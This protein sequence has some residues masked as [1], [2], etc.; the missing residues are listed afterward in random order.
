MQT[1][2][3]KT[4]EQ[5]FKNPLPANLAWSSIENLFLALGAQKIEGRGSRVRFELSGVI[6][7]FHRPHPQKEAKKYQV[8]G[9]RKFLEQTGIKL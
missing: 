8:K 6:A 3:Q 9:A 4:L 2:H 5:I 7:T 1:K